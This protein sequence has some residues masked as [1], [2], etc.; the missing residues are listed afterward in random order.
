MDLSASINTNGLEHAI[1]SF[2]KMFPFGNFISA[3]FLLTI[4]ISFITLADSMTSTLAMVSTLG[5]KETEEAPMVLKVF[6]GVF[7]GVISV[8]MIIYAGVDGFKMLANLA[9]FPIAFLLIAIGLSLIKG[10]YW[11][12]KVWFESVGKVQAES[13]DMKE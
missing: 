10:L 4:A 1:F 11:P 12:D 2:F 9:G 5:L 8:A 6:W 13:Q 7:I 3:V